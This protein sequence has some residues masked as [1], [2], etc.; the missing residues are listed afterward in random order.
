MDA[1]GNSNIR[2][3]HPSW[4][5]LG[6]LAI[7]GRGGERIV[8]PT[9][10]LYA[11]GSRDTEWTVG[12]NA[13]HYD[14]SA[15]APLAAQRVREGVRSCARGVRTVASNRGFSARSFLCPWRLCP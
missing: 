9:R 3:A 14:A 1:R 8:E 7:L 13:P 12:D 6:D 2:R 11:L 4:D 5:E 10:G 15:F